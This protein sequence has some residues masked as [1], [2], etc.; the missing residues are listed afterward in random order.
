MKKI[1]LVLALIGMIAFVLTGTAFA[2]SV[3]ATGGVEYNLPGYFFNFNVHENKA[4]TK[5]WGNAKNQIPDGSTYRGKVCAVKVISP[6]TV[7]FAIDIIASN[8]S[9]I[10]VGNGILVQVY[11][12]GSPGTKGPD[13]IRGQVFPTAA[14]AAAACA[15]STTP[16]GGP[17]NVL[18]GNLVVH[19]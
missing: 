4:G 10:W 15:A 19:K 7:L 14:L 9:G 2:G 3:K 18:S 5:V 1:S 17:W 11:D 13:T 12:G 6:D 8:I 16:S